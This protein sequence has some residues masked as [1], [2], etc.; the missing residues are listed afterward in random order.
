MPIKNREEGVGIGGNVYITWVLRDD[1][2]EK[3][4]SK[5]TR[6]SLRQYQRNAETYANVR[7]AAGVEPTPR[8]ILSPKGIT[9][10]PQKFTWSYFPPALSGY[11]VLKKGFSRPWSWI[12][13]HSFGYSWDLKYLNF[14]KKRLYPPWDEYQHN[15]S[16]WF[17][18]VNELCS[19]DGVI[20]KPKKVQTSIH[21]CISRRG[22][23]LCSVDLNDKAVHAGGDLRMS[24]KYT[25]NTL[26]VG[27]EL[28]PALARYKDAKGNV[29]GPYILPYTDRQMLA[30]SIVCKKLKVYNPKIEN[31]YASKKNGSVRDQVAAHT[32]GFIQHSDVNSAK[33]DGGSMF[34]IP[35]GTYG[36]SANPF[37]SKTR[38]G[39]DTLWELMAKH[40]FNYATDLF[41]EPADDS[42]FKDVSDISVA[43]LKVRNQG[44]YAVLQTQKDA[45]VSLQRAQRMQKQTR[46]DVY[47]KS[48][49]QA[50]VQS[51]VINEKTVIATKQVR[52]MDKDSVTKFDNPL[53]SYSFTT[54]TWFYGDSDTGE[55]V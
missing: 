28:E 5:K 16:R 47:K 23:V 33:L 42:S 22:D 54:G 49:A 25:N 43:L 4:I 35:V 12:M 36:H 7:V 6:S 19:P 40:N 18:A 1:D 21:F 50:K 30:L 31:Y 14:N 52:K 8:Y 11:R 15:P 41:I 34:D 27:I 10:H 48:L 53:L 44:Q 24:S 46:K 2:V 29:T 32:G 20:R 3:L 17:A 37:L 13:L 9:D 26:T 51:D 38:S 39:W 45:A 55:A